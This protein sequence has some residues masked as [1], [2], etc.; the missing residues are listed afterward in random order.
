MPLG[1]IGN[2]VPYGKLFGKRH[3]YDMIKPF[4]CLYYT[5]TQ[6]RIDINFPQALRL[7][8]LLDITKVKRV[9]DYIISNSNWSLSLGM[10][11]SRENIFPFNTKVHLLH[12]SFYTQTVIENRFTICI[13]QKKI[14]IYF[15]F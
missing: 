9:I 14:L 8:C 3:N 13:H 10:Y 2:E 12:P 7:V 1:A 4:G 11:C 6:K 5:F 15:K